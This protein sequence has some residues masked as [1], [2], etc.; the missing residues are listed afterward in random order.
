MKLYRDF[1]CVSHNHAVEFTSTTKSVFASYC[2]FFFY[3]LQ[4]LTVIVYVL[5]A[6][7]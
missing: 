3:N 2:V 6:S 5:F 7:E 4:D 1:N